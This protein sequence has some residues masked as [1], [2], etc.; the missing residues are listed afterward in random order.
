M[1][2]PAR[3][4]VGIVGGMGPE[5]TVDLMRRVIR[6]TPARDDADHI[7]MLVDSNPG[8]PSRIEA[9]IRGTG[10]SPVP[11]L[12]EMARGLE[13]QGADFLVIPC[14]T[15]HHYHAEVAA[16]V[17]VPVLNLVEMTARDAGGL[18]PVLARVG[19]LASSAL[20]RIRLYEPWF[21]RL[22]VGVLYP[23]PGVQG[24]L[25]DLI[26]A[27][28]AGR[29]TPGQVA[30]CDRA[31][32][33]LQARGAQCLVVACTELSVVAARLRTDLPVCDAVDVLAR[34]V[35]REALGTAAA[36]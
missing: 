14:N 17:D 5:A 30:A 27:V 26:R 7:R 8:V 31:A 13:R 12:V 15:A 3:K 33:D 28:K 34:A 11:C 22:G 4:T 36:A 25:M 20:M 21:E 1:N 29:H 2:A 24:E 16:A 10:E 19:L 23:E 9:L 35:I 32:E 18:C 6:G